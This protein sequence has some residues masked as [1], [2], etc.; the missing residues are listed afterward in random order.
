MSSP[1][2][3]K[4]KPPRAN[5]KPP[6]LMNFWRRSCTGSAYY[7]RRI[8]RTVYP[9]IGGHAVTGAQNSVQSP[10]SS[11]KKASTSQIEIWSTRNQWSWG[12]FERKV[13]MH[14]SYFWAPLRARYLH[15]TTAVGCPVESKVAYL[16]ITV[17]VGL[18]WK[19]GTLHKAVA[20]GG[21]F[22][23]VVSLLTHYIC[24]C[25]PLWKRRT[26]PLRLLLCSLCK[27]STYTKQLLL[28]ALV[29]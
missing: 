14:C 23:S 7:Q 6:L 13:L 18:L 1:L 20:I 8:R 22:E 24:Y 21:P 16:Y 9:P 4:A 28:G 15:I 17:A 3:M 12:A 2:G 26:Y 29:K 25:G 10:L 11:P 5:V 27:Q 19:Q